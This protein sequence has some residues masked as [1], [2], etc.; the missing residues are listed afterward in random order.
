MGVSIAPLGLRGNHWRTITQAVGLGWRSG[1]TLWL[2]GS[3]RRWRA[4]LRVAANGWN[5]KC[6][7]APRCGF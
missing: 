5:R 2:G 3:V 1:A 6:V 7:A 4:P